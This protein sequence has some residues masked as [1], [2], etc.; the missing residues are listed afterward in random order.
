MK[1]ILS[2]LID[3]MSGFQSCHRW[4]VGYSGGLDSHVLLHLIGSV[5]QQL[6]EPKPQLLAFHVDHGLQANSADWQGHCKN[7]AS[8]LNV[9][10]SAVSV[11]VAP[12]SRTSLEE[13]AR[14]ARYQ[15]FEALL[16]D[17]DLLLLAHHID[18]QLET[19]MQRL[20]RGSG[21]SG[22]MAIPR[23]RA[24]AKGRILR[25]LLNCS[26]GDLARYAHEYQ[27]CWIEDES[28]LDERHDRNYLRHSVMPLIE[29]RWPEY[30]TTMTRTISH[31]SEAEGLLKELAAGDL[32]LLKAKKYQWGGYAIS[33]RGLNCLAEN[34]Q[35]N[36]LRFLM[37]ALGLSMPSARHLDELRA[38]ASLSSDSQPL[39]QLGETEVRRYQD[40]LIFM[41]RLPP[42]D[43]TK[44]YHLSIDT[45]L[46][47]DGAGSLSL[48]SSNKGARIKSA[49]N[50]HVRFRK[51]G[52]R[53]KPV[54]RPH[55]QSLKK[56][57]QEYS[58]PPWFRDRIPLLYRGND[59]IA[60]AD[61]WI[62]DG[63]DAIAEEAGYEINWHCPGDF[64]T[65]LPA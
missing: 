31:I 19:L 7:E 36:V 16:G 59:L 52:E 24:L 47:L 46:D 33:C 55:S 50:L 20:L 53:C 58:I 9:P 43:L 1:S 63:F 15:A 61:L 44:S 34:R 3:L 21:I 26:R 45:S 8:K 37:D 65:K 6:P 4:V 51:G 28:N 56:L 30:R 22:L 32:P 54:G 39:L 12:L 5:Y 60:V 10:F 64:S 62:C 38:F 14:N 18:D 25:P 2:E 40:N 41:S 11:D 48:K 27:L 57:F 13:G 29:K 42:C 23:E 35:R 17:N 49:D